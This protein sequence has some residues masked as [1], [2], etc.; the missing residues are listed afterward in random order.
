MYYMG[1]MTKYKW[2]VD[3]VDNSEL[4][5]LLDMDIIEAKIEMATKGKAVQY[6]DDVL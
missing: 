3:E 5:A 1:W 4:E 2:T 6:I